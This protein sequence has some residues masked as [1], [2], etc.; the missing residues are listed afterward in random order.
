MGMQTSTVLWEIVWQFLTKINIVLTYDFAIALLGTGIPYSIAL[1]FIML[2][3]YCI[4]CKSKVLF[5]K[6]KTNWRQPHIK[7][8]YQH[9]FFQLYLLTMCLCVTLLKFLQNCKLLN[10][11]HIFMVNC[12]WWSL[13]LPLYLFWGTTNCAHIR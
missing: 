13:M 10:Y 8:V 4:F 2:H 12:D 6:T 11:Y 9:H 5:L 3:R 7:Q 1:H